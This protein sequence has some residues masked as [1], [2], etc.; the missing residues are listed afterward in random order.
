MAIGDK[1]P[2]VMGEG[3]VN[4]LVTGGATAALSAEMGKV[5]GQRPN[6]NL[7]HNWY[8]ANPV[9]QR[10]GYI[11]P[12]GIEA[13]EDSAFTKSVGLKT[14]TNKIVGYEGDA[15]YYL[16]SDNATKRY[17]HKED[18][19]SGYITGYTIDRW[20]VEGSNAAVS[21][22]S[23]GYINF[24][25]SSTT[26]FE[27]VR[28]MFDGTINAGTTLT[29]S[30]LARVNSVSG[31]VWMR[32]S[33][34]WSNMGH[35][36]RLTAT[37]GE[38]KLFQVTFTLTED[39]NNLWLEPI[40]TDTSATCDIDVKAVKLELGGTQTLAHQDSSGNWVLNEIPEY[41][42]ELA[43]CQRYYV[44]YG[45]NDAVRNIPAFV[46]AAAGGTTPNFQIITPVPLRALPAL[47]FSQIVVRTLVDK[48]NINV[49]EN[50]T[51]TVTALDDL[52]VGVGFTTES[53]VSASNCP[54]LRTL[55]GGYLELDAN[56]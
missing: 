54:I 27:R 16:L 43:K 26:T 1:R 6:P 10:D 21:V 20:K 14:L 5:L 49:S 36:V 19:V 13:F 31:E 39:I 7:L 30:M 50:K 12:V 51:P 46:T 22:L 55:A 24:A 38:F 4:D 47:R 53:A 52:S 37:D 33:K 25:F 8:F 44:R 35:G 29:F 41:S 11:A 23:D 9:N 28:Q 15:A 34:G 45:A 3:I 48:T 18:I 2:V 56:L 40:F 32:P 17:V 42:E